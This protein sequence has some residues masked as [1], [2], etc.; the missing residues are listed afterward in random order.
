[1]KQKIIQGITTA[2]DSTLMSPIA[3]FLIFAP[4]ALLDGSED[5]L[6]FFFAVLAL[7]RGLSDFAVWLVTYAFH[8][9][10]DTHAS[11]VRIQVCLPP[12]LPP[13]SSP[14]IKLYSL[15]IPCFN[16]YIGFSRL[17]VHSGAEFHDIS[18]TGSLL[19][20]PSQG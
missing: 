8:N 20:L 15:K 4:G 3:L 10:F 13:S 12:S 1:M 7:L 2:F 16:Q 18:W 14:L 17:P 6:P 19:A 9:G 5:A 11:L